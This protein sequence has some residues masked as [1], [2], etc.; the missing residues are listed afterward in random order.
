[1]KYHCLIC[2]Q[3]RPDGNLSCQR[4]LC[5]I[6]QRI[7]IIQEGEFLNDLVVGRLLKI[8]RTASFYRVRRGQQVLVM[9]L[10]HPDYDVIE[11]KDFNYSNYLKRESEVFFRAQLTHPSIP[12]LVS[13]FEGDSVSKDTR[14][15]KVTYNGELRYYL[16]FEDI[17]GKFL[18]DYLDDHPQPYYRH[19]GWLMMT[20]AEV[21]GAI[22]GVKG[23]YHHLGLNPD[24]VILRLDIDGIPRPMLVDLG[25]GVLYDRRSNL[26]SVGLSDGFLQR[27]TRA[28]L[29]DGFE[30]VPWLSLMIPSEYTPRPLLLNFD[31]RIDPNAETFNLALLMYRMLV[32]KLPD[33]YQSGGDLA[34]YNTIQQLPDWLEGGARI[35]R[36]DLNRR[37]SSLVCGILSGDRSTSETFADAL[38]ANEFNIGPVPAERVQQAAWRRWLTRERMQTFL[39]ASLVGVVLLVVGVVLD[40]LVR[41]VL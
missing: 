38:L 17:E 11:D 41:T 12:T 22:R 1:M 31:G 21:F 13:I 9:K 8:T 5:S 16:L 37:L 40:T 10:S 35:L 26:T 27:W 2:Q 36:P 34:I 3:F 39:L 19:A 4:L 14:Y 33:G 7:E 20:L 24:S 30:L 29:D 28:N 15:G 23:D 32:G 25:I 18:S 6:G